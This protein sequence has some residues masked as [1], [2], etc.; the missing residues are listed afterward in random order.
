MQRTPK[1][2]FLSTGNSSRSQ[3]AEGFLT[4]LA[5]GRFEAV[6]TGLQQSDEANPLTFEVMREVGIDISHQHPKAVQDLLKENFAYVITL[7]DMARE[8]SPIFPFTLNLVHWSLAD[9]SLTQGSRE[10]V[11]QTFRDV[12]DEIRTKVRRFLEEVK[13]TKEKVPEAASVRS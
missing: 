8:R 3:M 5:N 2:L 11:K 10:S 4:T 1:V 7:C 9:P 12:R 13:E 6:S